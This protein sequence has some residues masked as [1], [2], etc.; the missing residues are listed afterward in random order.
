MREVRWSLGGGRGPG[1]A[2]QAWLS[3][4]GR[5]TLGARMARRSPEELE[6]GEEVGGPLEQPEEAR[7]RRTLARLLRLQ[8][9]ARVR[10]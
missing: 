1:Q 2:R 7:A 3:L 6:L 8:V 5:L 10:A 9:R 4:G